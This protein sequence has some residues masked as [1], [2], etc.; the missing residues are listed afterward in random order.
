MKKIVATILIAIL[1]ITFLMSF[2]GCN[3]ND[4]EYG[5]TFVGAVS[6]ATY[7][8]KEDAVKGFL[9]EEISGMAFTA[10][11]VSYTKTADLSQ[12]E[13]D[14]L[15]IDEDLR[16]GIVSVEK[17]EVEYI[18][19]S[20]DENVLTKLANNTVKRLVYIIIYNING[21]EIYRFYVIANEIGQYVS[22]SSFKSIFYGYS[23]CNFTMEL[24]INVNNIPE[25]KGT[26]NIHKEIGK[27]T[28]QIVNINVSCDDE[29]YRDDYGFEGSWGDVY[30]VDYNEMLY[31]AGWDDDGLCVGCPIRPEEIERD[32][33][34]LGKL[35]L[36]ERYYNWL[37]I[38]I[39]SYTGGVQAGI[40]KC[41]NYFV[42]TDKGYK[43]NKIFSIGDTVYED[44]EIIVSQGNISEIKFKFITIWNGEKVKYDVSASFYDFGTTKVD[45]PVDV[46]NAIKEYA[47]K[48][49]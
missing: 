49:N 29:E 32:R 7:E 13:I 48:N 46:M 19:Q 23:Y 2:V 16:Y 18:E 21:N 10:E 40:D 31:G 39:L 35:P 1:A 28:E 17:G 37:N 14:G 30:Y 27:Y 20:Y 25:D 8:S 42:R 34:I 26:Y 38:C 12:K 3:N 22:A 41:Y 36:V 11:F 6:N 15:A 24:E 44:F 5:E 45:V 9:E 43:A 47:N 4:E 33:E